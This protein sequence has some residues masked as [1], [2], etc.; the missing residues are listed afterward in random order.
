M[1]IFEYQCQA[2]Q[3]RFDVLQKAGDP[4]PAACPECGK[5]RLEKCLSAPSFQLQ[6]KGWRKPAK[7]Q[8]NPGAPRARKVGHML[9]S[10]PPHSHDDPPPRDRRSP[11]AQPPGESHS[12]GAAHS[13]GH[14]HDHK[15]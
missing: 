8:G 15:H 5:K 13:H 9:D 3:H 11:A 2:C 1:P 12:H 10:A 6:G 4:A 7:P 14:P